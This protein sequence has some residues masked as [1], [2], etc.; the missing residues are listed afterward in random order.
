MEEVSH[1]INVLEE[2][3]EAI[4]RED[5]LKLKELS[6]LTI[7]S[8]STAQDTGSV[9]IAVIVY[10][11]SKII[12]RRE[13]F[14]IINWKVFI[15]KIDGII[16]LAIKA[17]K[18]DKI[19][20]Y[21]KYMALLRKTITSTNLNIKHSIQDVMRKASINKASRIYE[22]GI[23]LGHTAQ[24]LGITE[25]ELS[26]YAGQTKIPDVKFNVT[27]SVEKRAKLAMEFFK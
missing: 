23:S 9:T 22:H 10:A 18:E 8:A 27:I 2:T 26:E 21:E 5:V 16:S 13:V 20:K 17:L 19:D 12:E 1:V 3:K 7:H 24:I 15:K 11:L 14:K 25:W 6:N 4:A